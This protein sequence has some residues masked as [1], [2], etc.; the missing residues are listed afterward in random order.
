MRFLIDAQLPPV[1]C[2]WFRERGFEAE[3]VT[4]R[5]GGQAPDVEI[6][7][8]VAQESLVLITKDDD[9]VLRF[10]PD[11]YQLIWLRCGNITNSALRAWLDR[12]WTKLLAKLE[13]GE[14]MVEV[15]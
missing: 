2:A 3:H 12:R 1:L 11:D 8:R 6:A 10:P 14:R 7:A 9:F 5:L 15:R 13:A 4:E